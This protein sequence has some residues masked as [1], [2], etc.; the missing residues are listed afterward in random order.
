MIITGRLHSLDQ[1]ERI[2]TIKH[3]KA[4]KHYYI[5]RSIFNELEKYLTPNRFLQFVILDETRV[6]D[7]KRIATVDYFLRI[8]SLRTRK[9]IVYYDVRKHNFETRN[10]INN[11]EYKCFL[12][13]E[14]SMH[15]YYVDK[16]FV[17][18]VIQVG[19]VLVDKQDNIIKRYNQMIQPTRHKKITKRTKKFLKIEQEDVDNGIPFTEFYASFEEMIKTVKPAI[20]VWGKNDH[21]ALSEGYKVNELETLDPFTRYINLLQIHKNYFHLKNDLGLFNAL[22]LYQNV[23]DKQKHDALDD[24]VATYEIYKGFKKVLNGE[25]RVKIK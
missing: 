7:G 2:I 10:L 12:D 14:M 13:L 3:K 25:L 17:Q 8:E 5:Q 18:E 6:K 19:Y 16:N 23:K 21:L 15:P 11:L 22:K 20:F 4:I 9:N 1:T 24:A